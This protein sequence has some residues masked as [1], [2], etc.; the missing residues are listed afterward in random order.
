MILIPLL[1]MSSRA[2]RQ[3]EAGAALLSNMGLYPPN[4]PGGHQASVAQASVAQASPPA[5]LEP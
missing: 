4:L 1:A 2:S 3:E 5:D